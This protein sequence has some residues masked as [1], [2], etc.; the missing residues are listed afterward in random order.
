MLKSRTFP[1]FVIITDN[2]VNLIHHAQ[3]QMISSTEKNFIVFDRNENKM[4]F[5]QT[6]NYCLA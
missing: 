3:C 1:I 2:S 5:F 4:Y 6:L